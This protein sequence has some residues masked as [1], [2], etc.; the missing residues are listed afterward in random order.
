MKTLIKTALATLVLVSLPTFAQ[1]AKHVYPG[2][3]CQGSLSDRPLYYPSGAIH[4][5]SYTAEMDILC[6]IVRSAE[7]VDGKGWSRL[8]VNALNTSTSTK[9]YCDALTFDKADYG[10]DLGVISRTSLEVRTDWTDLSMPVKAVPADGY[11]LVLCKIPRRPTG[12]W[13][14][15]IASYRIEE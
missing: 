5:G 6:P 4:N 14:S 2:T 8:L 9:L 3:M 10:A 15:G 11:M 1:A 7:R 13:P 12:G